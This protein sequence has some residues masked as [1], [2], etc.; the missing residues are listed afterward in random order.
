MLLLSH[1]HFIPHR[2]SFVPCFPINGLSSGLG[3]PRVKLFLTFRRFFCEHNS[4]FDAIFGNVC[5]SV[6]S[7]KSPQVLLIKNA[8]TTNTPAEEPLLPIWLL[9]SM[10]PFEISLH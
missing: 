8:R 10:F 5:F 6:C 7:C 2:L 4:E 9:Y 1:K 3:F